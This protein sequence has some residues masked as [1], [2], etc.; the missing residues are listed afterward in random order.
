MNDALSLTRSFVTH[1]LGPASPTT[2]PQSGAY[3]DASFKP[4]L[5]PDHAQVGMAGKAFRSL[6]WAQGHGQRTSIFKLRRLCF[7]C[8]TRHTTAMLTASVIRNKSRES[9]RLTCGMHA[10][11]L[12][13][14]LTPGNA[15]SLSLSAEL[16]DKLTLTLLH[17]LR[18]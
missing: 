10:V 18:I 14:I 7:P 2:Q 16:G 17:T 4:A 6:L 5:H 13:S 12:R 3:A 11:K 1:S 9:E 8:L 15:L